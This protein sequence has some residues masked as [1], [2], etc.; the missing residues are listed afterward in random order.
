[1]NA[2]QFKKGQIPWNKGSKGIMPK[3]INGFQKGNKCWKERPVG[4]ERKT[5]DGIEV[6]TENGWIPRGRLVLG[7]FPIGYVV[8]HIDGD[9]YNDAPAEPAPRLYRPRHAQS[10]D[11]AMQII[12]IYRRL[13]QYPKRLQKPMRAQLKALVLKQRKTIHETGEPK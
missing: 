11:K 9:R 6:K 8:L 7:T 1:M 12:E 10:Q 4:S 3:P 5:R 13:N 2:G